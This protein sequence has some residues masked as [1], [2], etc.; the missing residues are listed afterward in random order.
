MTA[1]LSKLENSLGHTFADSTLLSLALT[2]RSFGSSNN[3]RLEFLGDSILNFLIADALYQKFPACR[4]GDLSRMRSLLVK[5]ETLAELALEL[6]LSEYLQLGSGE[7]KSGGHRRESILADTVEALIAAIYFDAGMQR[8][9]AQVL[10]W[11]ASRLQ[12]ITPESNHKDAKT[13]LQEYLQAR[14]QPLP[15]YKLLQTTGSEHQQQFEIACTVSL[16]NQ[17]IMGSGS[18]RRNAEQAAAARVLNQLQVKL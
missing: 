5:G 6:E 4:E 3:E 15:S 11:Y 13:L 14:K 12:A 1:N 8:C 7:L 16:L 10:Q 9:K 18:N 2:H 17:A